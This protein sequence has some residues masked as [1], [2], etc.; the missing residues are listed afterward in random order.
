MIPIL[1]IAMLSGFVAIYLTIEALKRR[2]VKREES[3]IDAMLSENET[4]KLAFGPGNGVFTAAIAEHEIRQAPREPTPFEQAIE[5][6]TR[7]SVK[8]GYL[9]GTLDD[10]KELT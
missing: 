10:L 3:P 8:T 4:V 5:Q 1:I 6:M 9:T 2:M 7:E